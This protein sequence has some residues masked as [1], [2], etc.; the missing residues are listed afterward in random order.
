MKA[1]KLSL[2][3][4]SVSYAAAL[5]VMSMNDGVTLRVNEYVEI[6]NFIETTVP[7][8]DS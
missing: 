6:Q 7:I 5:H 2:L 4:L 8:I 1:S 3:L